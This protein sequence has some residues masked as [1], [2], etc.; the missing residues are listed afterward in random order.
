MIYLHLVAVGPTVTCP[1]PG[2]CA[3][4]PMGWARLISGRLARGCGRA[5][6]GSLIGHHCGKSTL[7]VLDGLGEGSVCGNEVVDGGVVLNGR[8]GKVIERCCHLLRLF[9]FHGLVGTEGG[10]ACCH[11]GDVTHFGKCSHPVDLPVVPCVLNC[12]EALPFSP[13]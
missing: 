5:R 11:A 2:R 6:C 4:G 7:N 1:V 8:V 3:S 10:F 13:A 9:D 12:W